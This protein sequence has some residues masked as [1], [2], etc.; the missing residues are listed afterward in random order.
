MKVS[1]PEQREMEGEEWLAEW[2]LRRGSKQHRRLLL[3]CGP[4]LVFHKGIICRSPLDI[5]TPSSS[6]LTRTQPTLTLFYHCVPSVWPLFSLFTTY[7]S[8]ATMGSPIRIPR[9]PDLTTCFPQ[10]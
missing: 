9:Q 4:V 7:H 8:T 3:I 10:Y 2:R 5:A 6:S 1:G